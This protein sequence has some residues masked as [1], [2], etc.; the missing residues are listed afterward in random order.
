MKEFGFLGSLAFFVYQ[1]PIA[2]S[3]AKGRSSEVPED[4]PF[5]RYGDVTCEQGPDVLSIPLGVAVG[6]VADEV[7][8]RWH[9]IGDMEGVK[10]FAGLEMK[11]P[12]DQGWGA[13]AAFVELGFLS[14]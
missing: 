13:N 12:I 11:R 2:R 8:Q 7:G 5:F 6:R 1:F 9:P 3:H 10:A 4:R 14:S